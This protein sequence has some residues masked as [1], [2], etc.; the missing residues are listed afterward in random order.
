MTIDERLKNRFETL[1][2]RKR[3][4]KQ[5]TKEIDTISKKLEQG[6]KFADHKAR[7]T[8]LALDSGECDYWIQEIKS[9]I[10]ELQ[11][12]PEVRKQAVRL[13]NFTAEGQ[14]EN[15]K[16]PLDDHLATLGRR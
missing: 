13:C 2:N 14:E 3:E 4:A 12:P 10:E 7:L 11:A 15:D 6:A 1:A 5:I 8:E 16:T 9:Q